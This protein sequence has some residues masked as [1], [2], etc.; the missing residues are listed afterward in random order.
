MIPLAVTSHPVSGRRYAR[1]VRCF[2]GV[3]DTDV[4]KLGPATELLPSYA[5]DPLELDDDRRVGALDRSTV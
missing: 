4:D 3:S 1:S 5:S 2:R